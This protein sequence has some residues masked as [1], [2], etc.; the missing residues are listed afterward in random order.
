M[1]FASDNGSGA[2]PEILDALSRANEG[3]AR[4]YGATRSWAG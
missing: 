2:A 1:F 4:S 3:Y